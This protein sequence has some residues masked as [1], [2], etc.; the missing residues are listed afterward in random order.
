[1]PEH[2]F[3]PPWSVDEADSKL[4]RR[5]FIVRDVM[6]RRSPSSTSEGDGP[7]RGGEAAHP[8]QARPIATNIAKL[9]EMLS[10]APDPYRPTSVMTSTPDTS[11][12]CAHGRHGPQGDITTIHSITLSARANNASWNRHAHRL[13]GL[14]VDHQLELGRLF[15]G[16]VGDLSAAEEFDDLLGHYF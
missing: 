8:R 10:K 11:L 3:P 16:D 12:H 15:D 14:E 7:T 1:M 9:Q 2:R 13:S 4:D 5:C 6:G